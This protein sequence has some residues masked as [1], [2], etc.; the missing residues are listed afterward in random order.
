MSDARRPET[1][2]ANHGVAQDPHH[3][4]VAPT[5]T[6][7]ATFRWPDPETKP[8]FDYSRTVNPT[9]AELEGALAAL[10]GAAG[11]TVTNT[12]MAAI[13]LVLDL[14]R[15]GELIV[16]P[17]DAYGGTYRLLHSLA[18]RGRFEVA[19]I[20]QNDD[21]A[22]EAAL[23]NKPRLVWIETPSNPLMRIV[24]V[25]DRAKKAKAAGALVAADNTFLTPAR[26]RPLDLGCDIVVHSTTKFLNGHS[27]VVGGAVLAK[28]K[29]LVEEIAWWANN[30]GATGAP[31]DAYL[32]LRGLRTLCV[33]LDRQEESAQ[34]LADILKA[35]P[36]VAK[37][38]YPG[39]ADH[40]GRD[41][42]LRQQTGFGAMLSFELRDGPAATRFFK[43]LRLA[44]VAASLGGFETL[45]C[46]PAT[47]THA[48]MSPEARAEAGIHDGLVRVSVG[49][50]H[51]D[52]LAAD[53]GAG[54][55]AARA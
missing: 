13:D 20:D 1:L 25:A 53:F 33:R 10:E 34:A 54:L 36:A 7:S 45:V 12:G 55:K 5:I 37:V 26:Q 46:R 52:D 23:A 38:Y 39:L 18:Q 42:A 43:A 15:P 24:D 22:Y 51:I 47:M 3:G 8:A 40:P 32:T 4:A 30:V 9:R 41:I 48:G 14:I 31:F 28:D 16:A 50:E 49:L 2:V 35:D 19:F 11:C 21:T 27:D 44:T 29:A 17:H 6:L